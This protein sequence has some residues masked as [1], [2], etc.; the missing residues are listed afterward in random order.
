MATQRKLSDYAQACA[1]NLTRNGLTHCAAHVWTHPDSYAGFSPDGDILLASQ[2]RDSDS[3]TRSNFTCIAR[4]LKAEPYDDG[5]GTIPGERNHSRPKVY[6][7]RASHA[8]VGWVE[9]LL[10]RF[11]ASELREECEEM[12][13]RLDS[14]PVYDDDAHSQLES[15]ESAQWWQDMG[16]RGRLEMI[17]EYNKAYAHFRG[18]RYRV[19]IFAAR[20]AGDI[21]QDPSG[22]FEEK[23]RG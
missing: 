12:L 16:T 2:H 10:L 3:V 1:N 7:W 13:D 9:Y 4:D 8:A 15:D 20:R 22:W 5:R 14:Y 17:Q 23:L 19:S 18:S 21:P 11:D 6:H